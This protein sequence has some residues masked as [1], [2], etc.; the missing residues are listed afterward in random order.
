MKGRE[1]TQCEGLRRTLLVLAMRGMRRYPGTSDFDA[2][3]R[4]TLPTNARSDTGDLRIVL[5]ISGRGVRHWRSVIQS[6]CPCRRL[7]IGTQW[8]STPESFP[9]VQRMGS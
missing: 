5:H 6:P 1:P 9:D 8:K 2:I 7:E 4:S 3:K